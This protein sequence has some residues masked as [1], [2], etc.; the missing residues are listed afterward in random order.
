MLSMASM[1]GWKLPYLPHKVSWLKWPIPQF[2]T[3]KSSS[4]LKN[5]NSEDKNI[6]I[7]IFTTAESYNRQVSM[8]KPVLSKQITPFE[9]VKRYYPD[10]LNPR[11]F[12]NLQGFNSVCCAYNRTNILPR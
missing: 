11:K 8:K 5:F 9:A 12:T 2:H 4:L 1:W 6:K 10:K 3:N 7:T